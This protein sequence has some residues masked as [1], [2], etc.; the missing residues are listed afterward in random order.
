MLQNQH[1][2]G[3]GVLRSDNEGTGGTF[4]PNAPPGFPAA[5]DLSP[6]RN[7]WTLMLYLGYTKQTPIF[8]GGTFFVIH[9][10]PNDN[11]W[12]TSANGH[13]VTSHSGTYMRC[14]FTNNAIQTF[15]FRGYGLPKRRGGRKNLLAYR[16]DAY[17]SMTGFNSSH[18]QQDDEF[19]MILR[20]G[21]DGKVGDGTGL[22][23]AVYKKS[24]YGDGHTWTAGDHFAYVTGQNV[25]G[26]WAGNNWKLFTSP[27][28]LV[29]S[30]R[31]SGNI[32]FIN[33]TNLGSHPDNFPA[34]NG[35]I[36]NHGFE[37]KSVVWDFKCAN[38]SQIAEFLNTAWS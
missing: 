17:I 36:T 21:N 25:M 28:N 11:K 20:S 35:G 8:T 27:E 37:Y 9:N 24:S 29:P 4:G 30:S 38:D 33:G 32:L 18:L 23:L 6:R 34:E 13:S 31:E 12:G 16:D 1:L 26:R 3:M 15:T 19:C 7:G 5:V 2:Y 14:Q 22:S 10:R